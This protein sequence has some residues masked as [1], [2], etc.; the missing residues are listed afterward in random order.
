MGLQGPHHMYP[1]VSSHSTLEGAVE[2]VGMTQPKQQRVTKKNKQQSKSSASSNQE[3]SHIQREPSV[4]QGENH[5]HDPHNTTTYMNLPNPIQN[6]ICGT[7]ANFLKTDPVT[8]SRKNSPEKRTTEDIDREID[9]R[10]QEE[11]QH[12]LGN[13]MKNC[14]Q[15]NRGHSQQKK[16]NMG[17]PYPSGESQDV[18]EQ[19]RE[20][21]N[22]AQD[23]IGDYQ[24][25]PEVSEAQWT[26]YRG[27]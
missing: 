2:D 17:G 11:V 12:L 9:R 25:P 18:R 15:S 21:P 3:I 1:S 4:L 20:A 14:N 16:Q 6:K 7:Y 22:Q 24:R 27:K 26:T 23:L 8:S 10:V 19:H 13:T 5:L